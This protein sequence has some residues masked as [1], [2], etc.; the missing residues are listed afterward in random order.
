[1][2]ASLVLLMGANAGGIANM[3]PE[4]I[5]MNNPCNLKHTHDKWHGS[6]RLQDNKN[7]VRFLTPQAGLRAAMKT[8]LTY[9]DHY[10][11][12]TINSI[13]MRFAPPAENNTQAYIDDVSIR[14]GWPPSAYLDL[15][16]EDTLIRMTQSIVMHEN[17]HSPN[18]MP[19][20]WYEEAVYHAAAEQALYEVEE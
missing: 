19:L 2:I 5:R 6:A 7:F 14:M 8:L 9:E 18:G 4:G 1:M 16:D 12:T 20:Y 15:H 3:F 17:G 13:I 11:I 10:R